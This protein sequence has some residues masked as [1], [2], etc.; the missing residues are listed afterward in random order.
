M[1]ELRTGIHFCLPQV[2]VCGDVSLWDKESMPGGDRQG[3]MDNI[4]QEIFCDDALWGH[5]AKGA[6]WFSVRVGSSN[7]PKVGIIPISFHGITTIAESLEVTQVIRTTLVF[8]DDM[9]NL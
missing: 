6:A 7:S 4:R 1:E 3:I 9:I 8:G 2:K 5:L